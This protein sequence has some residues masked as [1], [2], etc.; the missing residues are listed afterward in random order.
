MITMVEINISIG[1]QEGLCFL[2]ALSKPFYI[3]RLSE[4][5]VNLAEIKRDQSEF[6]LCSSLLMKTVM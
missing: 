3:T 4:L 1:V 2:I 5:R 6:A